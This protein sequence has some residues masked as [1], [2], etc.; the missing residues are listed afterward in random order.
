MFTKIDRKSFEVRSNSKA[1]L[2]AS[3]VA[4]PPTSSCVLAGDS[5]R[6]NER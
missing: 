6:D 2:T 3:A 5:E 1:F 4:P